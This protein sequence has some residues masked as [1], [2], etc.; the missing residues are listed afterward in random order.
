MKKIPKPLKV[1]ALI[2]AIPTVLVYGGVFLAHKVF[3]P[4]ATSSV[5]T[6]A[7]ATDGVLTLGPQ[8]NQPTTIEAFLPLLAS[9][10]KRYND[11]APTLWPEN[12]VL[13]QSIIIESIGQNKFWLIE[14]DGAITSLPKSQALSY[15]F[16]R[17]AY[18]DGFS[19]FDGG[20][21]YA[22][23]RQDLTNY[24]KWQKYLH[25][26]T[27]DTILFLTHESFHFLEQGGSKWQ[28]MD[29]VPNRS[30]SEFLEE[31]A[32]R[33]AR[34]QL[35]R[36]LMKAVSNPN[37]TSSI[38]DALATYEDWKSQFPEDYQNSLYLDRIEGVANYYEVVTGL[39]I[40]YPDQIKDQAD[41]DRAFSLLATR[42]DVYLKHGLVKEGYNIGIFACALL[43]RLEPNWP[44]LI[45]ADPHATPLSL[46][47]DHFQDETLPP[48][49]PITPDQ[50][51][52]VA[53]AVAQRPD[54]K[55]LLFRSLYDML[56]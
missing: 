25:L 39:Y 50:L 4:E 15:G 35:Q 9:Q 6:I 14:P 49:Q 33:A 28:V 46:L 30:R 45:M 10:L 54:P 44:S 34:A 24:L 51:D 41:L 27:H 7:A 13:D 21:Y 8:E 32:A 1:L 56:F 37:D 19:F 12:T 43:E 38:L 16:S 31:T 36:Q 17:Q 48:P 22:L 53:A 52:A 5:P 47:S 3:F 55:P 40:G 2:I 20:M 18:V 42:E 23:S 29:E 26:G 11:L